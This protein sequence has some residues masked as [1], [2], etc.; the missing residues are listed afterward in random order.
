M[1]SPNDND[2]IIPI[3]KLERLLTVSLNELAEYKIY[4][5]FDGRELKLQNGT[6]DT[7][8]E[9]V[10]PRYADYLFQIPHGRP[11]DALGNWEIIITKKDF[12]NLP[13]HWDL[14][15]TE[16]LGFTDGHYLEFDGSNKLYSHHPELLKYYFVKSMRKDQNNN[17]IG[18]R[19]DLVLNE[20]W[21]LEQ[22]KIRDELFDWVISKLILAAP[23]TLNSEE[24]ARLKIWGG[25]DGQYFGT[26]SQLNLK[27]CHSVLK[28]FTFSFPFGLANNHDKYTLTAHYTPVKGGSSKKRKNC[29]NK[30]SRK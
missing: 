13:D 15:H 19:F 1:N 12:L 27:S 3:D 24:V 18:V 9:S 25:V 6:C 10:N 5:G 17:V 16:V 14:R 20:N 4:T 26:E 21:Q 7:L 11:V 29:I 28:G 8:F 23:F 2:E 22:K 30:K